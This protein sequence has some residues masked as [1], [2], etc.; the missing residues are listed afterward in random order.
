MF[1]DD[2]PQ[3][4]IETKAVGE[5]IKGVGPDVQAVNYATND[6]IPYCVLTNGRMWRLYDCTHKGKIPEKLVFETGIDS[7]EAVECIGKLSPEPVS[8]GE[9]ELFVRG[10]RAKASVRKAF[11]A[12]LR[13]APEE[14]VR[15]VLERVGEDI[16]VPLLSA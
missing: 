2:D 15:L 10:R 3:I 16:R 12:L 11:N 6:G 4:Y 1:V 13:E 14:L 9:I 8:W 5:D 7:K